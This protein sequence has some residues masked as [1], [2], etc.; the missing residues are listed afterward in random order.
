MK[1][2]RLNL[3]MVGTMA[4]GKSRAQYTPSPPTYVFTFFPNKMFLNSIEKPYSKMAH[5]VL[6]MKNLHL[7][8][9]QYS[10]QTSTITSQS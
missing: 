1:K 7:G 5:R 4:L 9:L 2:P 10:L 8:I 6:R 3:S